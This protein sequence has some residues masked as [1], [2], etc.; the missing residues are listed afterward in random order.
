MPCEIGLRRV[1]TSGRQARPHS[2]SILLLS[3][4]GMEYC[5]G[6]A[7]TGRSED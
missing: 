3:I 4:D 5:D 2:A 1:G 6:Y 7:N